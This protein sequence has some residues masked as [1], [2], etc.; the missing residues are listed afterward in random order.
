M[1]EYQ[2]IAFQAVDTI[3]T[4]KQLEFMHTQ[5]SRAEISRSSFT[6]EYN[7]GNFRGDVDKMLRSGYDVHL[8]YANYGTRRVSLRLPH[9]MPFPDD[10]WRRYF[11]E[12]DSVGWKKDKTGLGGIVD[13]QPFHDAGSIDQLWEPH[14]YIEDCVALRDRLIQGDLR[15]LYLVWL[16]TASSDYCEWEEVGPP[17]PHGLSEFS[18]ICGDLLG[19][20]GVDPLILE[21]ASQGIAPLE[22]NPVSRID[23]I[24][25]KWVAK[26]KLADA[27]DLLVRFLTENETGVKANTLAQIRDAQPSATWPS[28]PGTRS[29]RQLTEIADKLRTQEISKQEAKQKA[30]EKRRAKKAEQQRQARMNKMKTDPEHWLK[31]ASDLAAARGRD[32][33]KAASAI[34]ADLRDAIGGAKGAK[35]S[36]THA[37]HLCKKHPTLTQLK[38]L[39]RKQNLVD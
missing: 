37:A 24:A 36:R 10:I 26:T 32:N 6:N 29:F 4:N 39:L 17:V 34:L 30:K 8:H 25:K 31:E 20:F 5:S 14:E 18:D 33:Y 28:T 19:F 35:L 3:L 27:R 1:S 12:N 9:G 16:C 11:V 21:A 15:A 38:G 23:A 2:Y 7:F 13:L 22:N